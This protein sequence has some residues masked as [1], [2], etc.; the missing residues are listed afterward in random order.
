MYVFF[1][2]AYIQNYCKMP[3]LWKMKKTTECAALVHLGLLEHLSG[4]HQKHEPILDVYKYY[5]YEYLTCLHLK[6]YIK[7]IWC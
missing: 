3:C 6:V 7:I 1:V 2:V 5:D 4:A